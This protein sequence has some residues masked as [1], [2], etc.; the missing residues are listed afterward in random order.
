M[1]ESVR[2]VLE[3]A[4]DYAGLFPP[5]ARAIPD[6]V[7]RF[8]RHRAGADAWALGRFVVPAG[9]L[10]E[11]ATAARP[12]AA[13]ERW[14]V[15]A[16]VGEDL[17]GDVACV[18]AFNAEHA[19]GPAAW[20]EVDAVEWRPATVDALVADAASLPAGLVAYAEVA[21]DAPLPATIAAA[22]AAGVRA[23]V[24]TGGTAAN[25]FP[26]AGRLAEF[27]TACAAARLPFKATA[28]LHHA[29]RGEYALTYAPDSDR[30][31]MFGYLNVLLAS[32]FALA[33]AA[34]PA[35]AALLEVSRARDVEFT[36]RRVRWRDHTATLAQLRAARADGMVSFGS[37]SFAEPL[38]D[39][40]ACQVA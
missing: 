36:A 17:A 35:V 28:G 2:A 33:G 20:A 39:L 1:I 19:T 32:A 13:G 18:R 24:R 25:A 34:P 4:I 3:G 15:S 23:K 37:C 16:L 8:A 29:L 14:R 6:A 10:A 40:H 7:A 11:L 30:A 9:R 26:P 27:I 31:P 22:R 5:A 38:A 21:L 12:L